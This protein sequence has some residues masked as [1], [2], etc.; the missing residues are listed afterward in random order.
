MYNGQGTL[1]QMNGQKLYEG[2]CMNN[3]RHGHGRSYDK[4]GHIDY[5]GQWYNDRK[6]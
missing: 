5:E 2:D 6:I 4:Y 3:M 1:Y